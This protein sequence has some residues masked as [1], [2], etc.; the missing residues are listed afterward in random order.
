MRHLLKIYNFPLPPQELSPN[1]KL[2]R[3]V[4]SAA[5][6]RY[7]NDCMIVACSQGRER[8][9]VPVTIE[10]IGKI[11]HKKHDGLYRPTDCD[12]FGAS[13]KYLIDALVAVGIFPDDDWECVRRMETE[14]RYGADC[15][16]VTVRIYTYEREEDGQ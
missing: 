14:L 6:F 7:K 11:R 10:L 13:V 12:N 16:A 4:K 8:I 9:D 2:H 1:R 3:M 15:E 5:A